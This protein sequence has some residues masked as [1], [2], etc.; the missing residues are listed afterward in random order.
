MEDAEVIRETQRFRTL[1][2]RLSL[3]RLIL[4]PGK[5]VVK[6]ALPRV[7]SRSLR[8]PGPRL[9]PGFSGAYRR[10]GNIPALYFSPN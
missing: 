7:G 5:I 1:L 2:D 9:L 8:D 3:R 10:D 6:G 4:K